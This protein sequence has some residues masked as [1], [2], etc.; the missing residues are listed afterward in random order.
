[1]KRRYFL[2]FIMLLFCGVEYVFPQAKIIEITVKMNDKKNFTKDP[3]SG[4]EVFGFYDVSK[5]ARTAKRLKTDVTFVPRDGEDFDEFQTTDAEGVCE[6]LLPP[7]GAVVVRPAMGD[8][9]IKNV[10]GKLKLEVLI[11]ADVGKSLKEVTT[12]AKKL[13]MNKP[14]PSRRFGNRKTVGPWPFII[15]PNQT[16]DDARTGLA[17]IVTVLEDGDTFMI[18]RPFIKDGKNYQQTQKRRMGYDEKNDPLT[19]YRSDKF[20]QTREE[21]TIMFGL[22][23]YPIDV[24]KHY[25]VNATQ[26]FENYHTVYSSDSVCLDEGYDL[27]P[28]RFLE[29]DLMQMPINMDRY[30]RKGRREMMQDKRELNLNFM[31]GK[32][33]LDPAD[34]LNFLQLNQLK[35]DLARYADD[36]EAG[37]YGIEVHGQ[38][39]PDGGI[40][41]NQRLC[42]Q[43]SEYLKSEIAAAFPKLRSVMKAS[44]SVAG[45]E[46]VARLLEED[47]LMDYANEVKEIIASNKNTQ[48]QER[49]IRALPY[50]DMIKEKILPRLRVVDFSF[51]YFTNRVRTPEEVYEKYL[52][53]PGYRSGKKL[54]PYEF[55]YLFRMIKEPAELEV[56]AKEALKSV[57]DDDNRK[58]WPLA[59]YI[60]GQCYLQRDTSDAK[61][62]EPYLDWS[63]AGMATPELQ[64]KGFG[65]NLLGW[66]NDEAIVS[67]YITHL[68][69]VGDYYM[70]DSV[71]VNLLPDDP[72]FYMTKRFLDCLNGMYNDPEVRDTVAAT[73]MMNKV[74][75]YAAQDDPDADNEVFHRQAL[76]LLQNDTVHF[77]PEDPK[78]LY[79]IATLRF[80]LDAEN[81]TAKVYTEDH[82]QFDEFFEPSLED[83]TRDTWGYPRQDWGYPMIQCCQKDERFLKYMLYDG[84]FNEQYRTAFMK[85]WKKLKGEKDKDKEDN[86]KTDETILQ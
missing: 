70:A 26:W 17:P 49:K 35:E 23:L 52:T 69:K 73:S 51:S 63:R 62:F 57:K 55:Y 22:M 79:M 20:M 77:D 10:D 45:W 5:A 41:I 86:L 67:S 83:P 11:D 9:V 29:Y 31:V 25:R 36:D 40:A 53:D 68:C 85:V 32:A 18:A 71:A 60:L 81:K 84:E 4:A 65:G 61:L 6:M 27:E 3:L 33:E 14:R 7:I 15:F 66:V 13:R 42:H 56:L 34:S 47:S 80:R 28:M 19:A 76:Y 46:D 37:I 12:T 64:K 43:R 54:K 75:L 50:Y 16:R 82:F 59:A 39:S 8:P 38:A 21:D 30:K 72:R 58:P 2:L 1:M 24:K 48:I 78:V 74:V 44:A